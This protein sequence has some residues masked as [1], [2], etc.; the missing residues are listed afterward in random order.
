MNLGIVGCGLIGHKRARAVRNHRSHRILGLCDTVIEKA[1]ELLS[2]TKSELVTTDWKEIVE[3]KNIDVVMVATTHDQLVPISVAAVEHGKHVLIEKPVARCAEEVLPLIEIAKK[4]KRVVQVGFNH[5]FHPALSQAKELVAEGTI[6]TLLYIRAR[7]GNGARLNFEKEWRA[8]KNIS[9]GGELIDQ[10]MHLIDLS[11]WFLGDFTNVTGNLKT[12]FWDM[13]VEDNAFLALET[14]LKQMAWLH[15][16]WTEWKNLFCFEIFGKTG[17]LEIN[18]LGGSYGVEKLTLY[19]MSSE[20]GP[21]KISQWEF[22]EE[23]RSWELEFK[24][25]EDSIIKSDYSNRS[26]SDAYQALSIVDR[27][28]RESHV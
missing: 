19:Q 11:R 15:V 20:M 10:G 18:G 27:V 1:E 9:G 7:Y 6:G 8:Q 17:K 22:P 21:P 26:L 5:R 23:D 14:P 24:T 16:S 3:S 25:F 4:N 28:Y 12:Y 2:V 13:K